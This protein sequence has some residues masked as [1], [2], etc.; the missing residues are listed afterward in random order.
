MRKSIVW[1]IVSGIGL[2]LLYAV[3]MTVLSRSAEAAWDQ[4]NSLWF[5]M[6]PLAVG[7]GIQVGLYVRLR[8]KREMLAAGG[9]TATVGMLA[10]CA[11]HLSDV[12]PILGLSAMSVFLGRYQ[13]PILLASI[14]INIVGIIWMLKLSR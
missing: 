12:L 10:C 11:H 6:V 4:F 2:L 9:G 5:L 14:G 1:G 13:A 3:T 8:E 7:F